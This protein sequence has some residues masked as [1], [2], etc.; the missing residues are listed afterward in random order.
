[1]RAKPAIVAIVFALA[2]CNRAPVPAA[3]VEAGRDVAAGTQRAGGEVTIAG[4][5]S[6]AAMLT[7]T[8]PAV[9]VD[10]AGLAEL[11]R[12]AA[13][14]LLSWMRSGRPDS[15]VVTGTRRYEGPALGA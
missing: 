15:P 2:A 10:E 14:N 5:D 3:S 9:A 13:T 7:W 12:K 11:R 6:I 4:D 1:M 8:P